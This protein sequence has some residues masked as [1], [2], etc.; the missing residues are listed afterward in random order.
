MDGVTIL[1]EIEYVT[2]VS[3]EFNSNASIL[4]LVITIIISTI[5]GFVIGKES[6]EAFIGT[7]VGALLGVVS[8]F[9]IGAFSGMIFA[10][11]DETKTTTRYEVTLD[12]SVSMSEFTNKYNIIEQRGQ[13][14]VVEDKEE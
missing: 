6:N 1:N 5:I 12:D 10:E 2:I 8:G 9:L 11:P 4:A 14:W 7:V 3:S 13:I